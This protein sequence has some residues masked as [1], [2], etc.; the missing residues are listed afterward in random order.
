MVLGNIFPFSPRLKE[1]EQLFHLET[2]ARKSTKVL[3]PRAVNGHTTSS[4]KRPIE[5]DV[6]EE[7]PAKRTKLPSKTDYSR[8]RLLDEKGR[9]TWHYLEDDEEVKKWPQSTADKYFLGLPTVRSNK[10]LLCN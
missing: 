9:Q 2:M 6:E 3:S 10:Q 1:T 8:W 4:E 5:V 7:Q